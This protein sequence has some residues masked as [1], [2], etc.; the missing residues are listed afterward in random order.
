MALRIRQPALR[1]VVVTVCLLVPFA[2][3][4]ARLYRGMHH[5]SDVAVA[6]VN[7]LVACVLAWG[8]LRREPARAVE[9]N[10]SGADVP[11][12]DRTSDP[13]PA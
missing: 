12:H 7:G 2:V 5:L 10:A 13:T 8:W 1:A 3:A 11:A 4:S 6:I 9:G